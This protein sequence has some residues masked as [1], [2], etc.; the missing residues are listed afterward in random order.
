M[1]SAPGAEYADVETNKE[2]KIEDTSFI[3]SLWLTFAMTGRRRAKRDGYPT[4]P[5]LGRSSPLRGWAALVLSSDDAVGALND[6]L[7]D[8]QTESFGG[9]QIDDEFE[10]CWLLDR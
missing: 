5:L 1:L 9:L 6:R 8:G 10:F 2:A 7:R 4:A 3:C